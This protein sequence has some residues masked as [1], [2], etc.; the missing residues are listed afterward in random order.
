M[1]ILKNK[2]F[3]VVKQT[4]DSEKYSVIPLPLEKWYW[5][6][7]CSQFK[8]EAVWGEDCFG[9]GLK[10][11]AFALTGRGKEEFDLYIDMITSFTGKP[12]KRPPYMHD[13]DDPKFSFACIFDFYGN[14]IACDSGAFYYS[15]ISDIIVL[16]SDANYVMVDFESVFS[17]HTSYTLYQTNGS[18]VVPKFY[19]DGY[20]I[21]DSSFIKYRHCYINSFMFFSQTPNFDDSEDLTGTAKLSVLNYKTG[22]LYMAIGTTSYCHLKAFKWNGRDRIIDYIVQKSNIDANGG[23]VPTIINGDDKVLASLYRCERFQGTLDSDDRLYIAGYICENGNDIT[24]IY[25]IDISKQS[26]PKNNICVKFNDNLQLKELKVESDQK[27]ILACSNY[28]NITYKLDK[29][30]KSVII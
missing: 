16:L 4:H 21:A 18:V 29:N 30:L 1:A 19:L 12:I 23:F 11:L 22:K 5:S 9:T 26:D 8:K 20:S 28:N 24:Y 17:S 2:K 10:Y 13:G 27:Y 7:T 3:A 6:A 25:S 14:C 15:Y